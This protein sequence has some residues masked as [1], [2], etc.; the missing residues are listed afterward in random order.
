M[1]AREHPGI[2]YLSNSADSPVSGRGPYRAL[3]V[4]EYYKLFGLEKLHSERGM[5]CVMNIENMTRSFG[6]DA[7][8]PVSTL[9]HPNVMYGH[10]DYALGNVPGAS[11]AQRTDTFNNLMAEAFGEPED[12]E[13]FTKWSQWLTYNGYRAIFEARSAHRRGMLLWMSHPSW[14]SMVWQTYDYYFEP[15]PAYFACRK[16]CEPMHIQWNPLTN[17]VEAV[18]WYASEEK[19]LV[20]NAE[21]LNLDGSVAWQKET[22]IDLGA[23]RTVS[24]FAL[25]FPDSLSDVF[26]VRLKLTDSNGRTLSENFYWE[27]R[28]EGNWKALRNVPQTRL[29]VSASEVWS[30]DEKV[31]KMEVTNSGKAPALM[32]RV[33]VTDSVTGDLILPAWYSD[34]YFFMMPGESRTLT[35]R[36]REE[37]STGDPV[38]SISGLNVCGTHP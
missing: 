11:S 28:Q 22:V 6:K 8:D 10:H 14:P 29:D 1:T 21:I 32:L 12:A 7:I 17:E 4:K 26:F 24:C 38:I 16:A 33:K 23:D 27:G 37:D 18:S 20:V 19:D 3:P 30:G 25:E 36:V 9:A 34:N 31:M 15:T 2:Y 5:P 13:E 35:V